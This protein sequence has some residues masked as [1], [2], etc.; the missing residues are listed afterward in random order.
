MPPKINGKT[1]KDIGIDGIGTPSYKNVKNILDGYVSAGF[2]EGGT[3][4]DSGSG[5]IDVAAIKGI[6]KTTVSDTGEF[7]AFNTAAQTD[8][9]LTD[10]STNYVYVDYN[11]GTPTVSVTA[12]YDTINHKTQVMI[13]RVFRIGTSLYISNI[14]AK[15][16][17]ATLRDMYRVRALRKF[18]RASGGVLSNP[19]SLYLATTAMV[20]FS[21][22]DKISIAAIDTSAAGRFT[23]W[24]RSA[25]PG[26][27][28]RVTDQQLV[29]NVNYDDG[30]GTLAAV[31]VGNFGV[32]WVYMTTDGT[33]HLQY[34]QA[35]Y[36]TLTQA[37]AATLPA[38]QP[39]LITE[40]GELIA[41]III[42]RNATT[43]TEISVAYDTVYAVST[44]PVHNEL[45]SLQGGTAGEYYHLTVPT[46]PAAGLRNVSAIDNGETARTD[47]AL[48]DAT[49]PAT[50]TVGGSGG[51]GTAMT[52][53]RRDHTHPIT[54]P[55]LDTLAACT[56][57]TTR[58]AST[59]A[60]GLVVKATA[61]ASG[62]RN[63]VAIDNAETAYTN[64]ALF[65]ATNPAA[66]GTAGTGSAMV[67]AR[68]DHIHTLPAIDATA[69]ATDITT[70]NATTS[71]HGL[72]IK[73]TAPSSGIRN[74]VCIDNAETVYKNSALFDNTDPA[75]LGTAN[76]GTSLIAARR[77]HVHASQVTTTWNALTAT[78]DFT[79]TAL[80][81]STIDMNTDQTANIKVGSPIRF[82]LSSVVYYAICT[83]I[84][85]TVLTI[86]GAPLT[87]SAGALTALAYGDVSR[88][89]QVTIH[90]PG[91]Y[92]ETAYTS[93][94]FALESLLGM[95]YGV[96]WSKATAY[97]VQFKV[98]N[99]VTDTGTAPKINVMVNAAAVGTANTNT[100]L[101]VSSNTTPAAT[102]VDINTSNYDINT[103]EYIEIMVTKGT[104]TVKAQDLTISV[105]FVYP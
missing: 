64:K 25:T 79:T 97:C 85:S 10:N 102:V 75:A 6:I 32:F 46:A 71:A 55:A 92:E 31:S 48:F 20:G 88:A 15:I 98:I 73:A 50:E 51:V 69:A 42:A 33:F 28:T 76:S 72:V 39:P 45:A 41:K 105:V 43:I 74:V 94:P 84:T 93:A 22:Y 16:A 11:A 101:S 60:H 77:D 52:A 19:S 87:T 65:D 62:L 90:I 67:A 34:G 103:G 54:N 95:R 38:S 89:E 100:G 81:T 37:R 27:W 3:I 63:V 8:V 99:R 47:K 96:M 26:V 61:P 12:S 18:E 36:G 44:A 86:G 14:G 80:S 35:N 104:D 30:D 83:A 49:T 59:S 9:S 82:T 21:N 7:V 13:G 2:F 70:R 53:A 17:N 40:M 58:D 66:L 29:D 24:Y 56:D 91:Y 1:A 5:Q 78:T 23:S 4:T 57:I 68:R